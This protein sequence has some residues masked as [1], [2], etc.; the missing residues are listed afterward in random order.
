M[1]IIG[2]LSVIEDQPYKEVMRL[3]KLFEKQYNS[4]GVQIFNHPNLTFQGGEVKDIKVLTRDFRDLAA[5]IEP[6][7]IEVDG[8]GRFDKRVIYIRVM[9]SREI[10]R[11][12]EAVDQ[13]LRSSGVAVFE[14]YTPEHWI[15]HITV[16]MDDLV[17]SEFD[18]AWSSLSGVKFGFE[19]KLHN[20]CLVK[21]HS[22]G[23]IKILKKF[24]L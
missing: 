24:L 2:I 4:I 12:N 1:D 3:W 10:A 20:I 11:I 14:E 17:G 9:K 15:P 21:R 8:F 19:Q 7:K 18:K 13:L 6:F 16:A 5:E 23:K 22:S